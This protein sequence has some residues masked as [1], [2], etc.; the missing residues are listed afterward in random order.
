MP[1]LDSALVKGLLSTSPVLP[2][3]V[4]GALAALLVVL[5]VLALRRS[6][7]GGILRLLLPVSGLAIG[8]L[9]VIAVLDRLALDDRAADGRA[10]LQ[11]HAE[12][13][14]SAVA[15]GSALACLDGAAGETV[16]NACEKAVFADPQRAASAVA[17]TAARLALLADAAALA[18]SGAP[19]I[20]EAFEA[21]RRAIE[22]DR[23]GVVAHVLAVRDGCTAE[24]CAAF[25]LLRD[26]ATLKANLTVQAFDTYVA[27]YASSWN[28]SDAVVAEKEPATTA[29][30]PA[31]GAT[32]PPASANSPVPNRYD[33]PS[34]ASIPPVSI[35]TSEPP[36]P[37]EAAPGDATPATAEGAAPTVKLPVPPK[38]PQTQAAKPSAR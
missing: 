3:S 6:G 25:D 12:L 11:R 5:I 35:M 1:T 9:A 34:A 14:L 33:F 4:T 31:T 8:A 32:G 37:K 13:N 38:R 2:A 17:Y 15:P 30:L 19:A 10:L 27:R 22:L 23:Y 18:H 7:A 24:R 16:E 26:T 21:T 28:K 20:T 36:M 29:S